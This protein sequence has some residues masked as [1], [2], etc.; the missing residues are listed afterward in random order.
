MLSHRTV[1][2]F[3]QKGQTLIVA[4]I[5]LGVLLILGLVFLG[6]LNRNI[7]NAARTQRRSEAE[8]LAEAAIRY[9][10]G[11]LV[12][13]PLGA[14]WRGAPEQFQT[15]QTTSLDPDIYYLRPRAANVFL[16]ND[17]AQPD[18]GG[19][20]GLGPF[21]RLSFRDGRALVRVRYGATDAN[22]VPVVPGGPLRNPG[23]AR[24][25]LIIEAIGRPGV[26]NPKDPTTLN[27]G[28]PVTFQGFANW[29]QLRTG[30]AAMA[31]ADGHL[32]SSR[33][34][35]AFAPIGIIDAA[36]FETNVFN[37]SAPIDLGIPDGLGLVYNEDPSTSN[38]VDVATKLEMQLG[39]GGEV[40]TPLGNVR[41]QGSM[42]V[43]GD[44]RLFGNTSLYLNRAL[45][46]A[47]RVAGS[48][49]AAETANLKITL[50][51]FNPLTKTYTGPTTLPTLTSANLDSKSD[52]FSTQGG[53]LLDGV[54]RTDAAGFSRGVGRLVPPSI[55]TV[56]PQSKLNRYVA[57]TRESGIVNGVGENSGNF[58]HGQ[59]VYVDNA[60][61][62][63]EEVDAVGRTTVGSQRSMFDDWMNPNSGGADSGW[64]GPFYIP[65]AAQVQ[66]LPDGWIIQRDDADWRS[67]AGSPS[68]L[69]TI[70]YRVGMAGT[71]LRVIDSLTAPTEIDKINPDFTQGLPFNGVLYFEGNVRVRGTIPTGVQLTLVSGATIYIDGSI[72]KGIQNSGGGISNQAP[73]SA[74]MLMA[75]D[76]VAV[77]TTMFFGPESGQNLESVDD[78]AGVTGISPVRLRTG[79]AGDA[80]RLNLDLDLVLDPNGIPGDVANPNNPTTWKPY[81]LHYRDA[82]ADTNG[83]PSQLVL[84]HT[85]EDG[86]G[87]ASFLQ[88]DINVGLATSTY[89]FN[90][91][92][93]DGL[94]TNAAAAYAGPGLG[95][96]TPLYGLGSEGWQK[97]SKFE[98]RSFNLIADPK[99]A[100]YN[101]GLGTITQPGIGYALLSGRNDLLLRAG[102]MAGVASNDY[103]VGRTA[104]VP[105]DIRIE[106]S[107]FAEQGSFF[108]IPGPWFNPNP[109]DTRVAF[110]ARVNALAGSMSPAAATQQASRE[111]LEDYGSAPSAPFYGEPLD[112]RVV[113][114]GS[115]AENLPPPLSMQ[116]EWIRKWGW[117]PRRIASTGFGIPTS[118]VP[119]GF[120]VKNT[121]LIVPNLIIQYDPMLATGRVGGATPTT[122]VRTDEIGRPLPP[123]PRLPVSPKLAYFG[124]L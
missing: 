55:L 11:Q 100:T 69:R 28:T 94:I 39:T 23:A 67:P 22:P 25:T 15:G 14:D 59:G 93:P 78:N 91:V 73:S 85:M 18:L 88:M 75:K 96:T 31:Q 17:P 61:D 40:S 62:R 102:A 80:N 106:A 83:V 95:S 3:R 54:S 105:A 65:I 34:L 113:L 103:L 82:F 12:S 87:D 72:V 121:D 5:I 58:G 41:G 81:A 24:S 26:V 107:I 33:R 7:L 45:G 16:N 57:I 35:V 37:S 20:D 115:V 19:P 90:A 60:A 71:Q 84:A 101:A 104:V 68:G 13:S 6:L 89:A 1:V 112:V 30:L 63:Q 38:Q 76:N 52:L 86:S 29:A 124:E 98:T 92:D 48:I 70:R 9:A 119:A 77:N 46:D 99:T 110:Q 108:V 8:D 114:T 32:A 66:L 21:V 116:A 79:G 43:N 44:L 2:R 49:S 118:H 10:H 74:L 122:P 27:T 111:R 120:D 109:N 97:Y 47:V 53:L 123:M 56:D 42:I 64:R 36:R 51:D 4:L 117:I 50:Y